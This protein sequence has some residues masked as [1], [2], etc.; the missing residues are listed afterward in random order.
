MYSVIETSCK[1]GPCTRGEEMGFMT[2]WEAPQGIPAIFAICKI[3]R[4]EMVCP[5]SV[6]PVSGQAGAERNGMC[7][8][9]VCFAGLSFVVSK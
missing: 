1:A 4:G 3:P 6:Y 8:S 7:F 9:S 2:Y 5:N